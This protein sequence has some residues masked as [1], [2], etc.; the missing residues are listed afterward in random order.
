MATSGKFNGRA[1]VAVVDDDE[2]IHLWLKDV[3]Q[4]QKS[5]VFAGGFSTGKEALLGVPRLCPDLAL[6]DIRLPDVDGI[7]CTKLLRQLVPSLKI[8]ILSGNHD[9][10]SIDRATRAGAITY[11]LKPVDSLQLIVTL[12]VVAFRFNEMNRDPDARNTGFSPKS[13]ATMNSH[14]TPREEE[15]LSGLAEGLYYK[16]I[17]DKLGITFGTVHKHCH[18]IYKKFLVNNRSEAIRVWLDRCR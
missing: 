17:S 8:I 12:Q 1:R 16:E 9:T 11:L 7:Q 15:V 4:S 14:L 5:L 6:V 2:D 3:L 13:A 18:N 10:A